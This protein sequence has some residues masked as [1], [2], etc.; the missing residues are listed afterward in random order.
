[1]QLVTVEGMQEETDSGR[2]SHGTR[3][4]AGKVQR[5]API[6]R[7]G[8]ALGTFPVWECAQGECAQGP[9]TGS[10]AAHALAVPAQS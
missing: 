4:S 3:R 8:G 9:F 6:K 10:T 7:R 1:M 5:H 2:R